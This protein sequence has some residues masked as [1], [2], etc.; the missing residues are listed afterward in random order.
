MSSVVVVPNVVPAS[1]EAPGLSVS[2]PVAD[3]T[4]Y[5]RLYRLSSRREYSLFL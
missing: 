4:P 5:E 2:T 1:G 3:P